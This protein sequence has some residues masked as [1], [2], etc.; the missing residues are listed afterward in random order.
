MAR[1]RYDPA[2]EV[3]E[4]PPNHPPEWWEVH[5]GNIEVSSRGHPHEGEEN[6]D[7]VLRWETS[8]K[9]VHASQPKEVFGHIR[10]PKP[11]PRKTSARS[12]SVSIAEMSPSLEFH[13]PHLL[14]H[15]RSIG[16]N[17]RDLGGRKLAMKKIPRRR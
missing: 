5:P 6:L 7:V 4:K 9:G 17:V 2:R 1:K 13:K 3:E 16:Y 14:P 15:L 8:G 12:R 11:L 10:I